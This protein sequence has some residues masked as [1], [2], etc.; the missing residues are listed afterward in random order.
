MDIARSMA[1]EWERMARDGDHYK[2]T[3]DMEGTW[4]LK[5]NMI[6]DVLFGFDLFPEEVKEKEVSYYLQKQ[7]R[8][9][10]P[11]DHR[12]AHTK[13]DWIF[14]AA[15]LTNSDDKFAKLIRP[16]WDFLHETPNRVPFSDWYDTET[17][18]HKGFVNR[19]VV[20]GLFIKLLKSKLL[21]VQS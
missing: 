21:P 3:F 1:R 20:G 8:Y 15:S 5:Y 11:L 12:A 7:N 10:V 13:A 16:V 4:S 9:G 6:W 17:G 19:S 14:W 18:K 2:L